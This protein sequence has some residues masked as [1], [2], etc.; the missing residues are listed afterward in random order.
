M[1]RTLL[2]T[3]EDLILYY[4]EALISYVFDQTYAF[5]LTIPTEVYIQ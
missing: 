2:I 1:I 5:D 4:F 3:S